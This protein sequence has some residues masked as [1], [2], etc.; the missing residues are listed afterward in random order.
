[1]YAMNGIIY[2]LSE[3]GEENIIIRI[4]LYLTG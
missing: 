4:I 1:M 3:G 2:F